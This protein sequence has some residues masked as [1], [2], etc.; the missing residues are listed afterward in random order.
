MSNLRRY[1]GPRPFLYEDHEMF[2]GRKNETEFLTT[3][4]LNNRTTVLQGKS[5]YGKSSL[6][7]AG[8]I[9]NI[10]AIS[11][12]E[13]IKIRFYNYDKSRAITPKDTL[14][15]TLQIY[16]LS[17][18]SYLEGILPENHIS[19]WSLLK[20]LHADSMETAKVGLPMHADT[21]LDPQLSQINVNGALEIA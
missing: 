16:Q 9:P 8:I 12:A 18:G 15:K 4:I 1:P 7:N 6:I 13:I 19:A 11:N 10:V 20:K 21:R 14:L 5:G 2:F 3:L 17:K